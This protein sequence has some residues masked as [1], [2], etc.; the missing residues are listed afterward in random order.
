MHGDLITALSHFTSALKHHRTDP[1]ET[2]NSREKILEQSLVKQ[3]QIV[4]MLQKTVASLEE[5]N[6]SAREKVASLERRVHHLSLW[7]ARARLAEERLKEMADSAGVLGSSSAGFMSL[8][9]I[10]SFEKALAEKD[11][12][13]ASLQSKVEGK[14]GENVEMAGRDTSLTVSTQAKL[15]AEHVRVMELEEELLLSREDS[16]KARGELAECQSDMMRRESEIQYL[17]HEIEAVKQVSHHQQDV[18]MGLRA[19]LLD[20]DAQIT[21]LTRALERTAEERKRRSSITHSSSTGP[22]SHHSLFDLLLGRDVFNVELSRDVANGE[23]G[24]SVS[25]F[26][27]PISSRMSGLIVRAVREG[28]S[29][30]GLLVPGDEILEVNGLNCRNTS[31]KKAV[32]ILERGVGRIKVVAAREKGPSAEFVRMKISPIISDMSHSTSL[33]SA[34]DTSFTTTSPSRDP[35][36]PLSPLHHNHLSLP[37]SPGFTLGEIPPASHVR[38][39]PIGQVKVLEPAALDGPVTGSKDE[40]VSQDRKTVGE[41]ESK[42]EL[43]KLREEAGQWQMLQ[44]ELEGELDAT[45]SELEA[46][47]MEYQ[48]TTAEN[49]D[50]QQQVKESAT[51]LAHIQGQVEELQQLLEGVREKIVREEERTHALEQHNKDLHEAVAEANGGRDLEKQR[52][53]EVEGEMMQLKLDCEREKSDLSMKVASLQSHNQQLQADVSQRAEQLESAQSHARESE[54]KMESERTEWQLQIQ[55][56]KTDLQTVKEEAAKAASSSHIEAEKLQSQLT[57]VKSLLMSAEKKEA[58]MKIEIRHLS[59]A[60]DE[61]NKQLE[62]LHKN[63]RTLRAETSKFREQAEEKTVQCETLTLGLKRAECKLQANKEMSSRQ[64]NEIDKLR[65]SNKQLHVERVRADEVCSKA[66]LQ[67]RISQSEQAQVREKLQGQTGEKEELFSQL[68]T[69]ATENAVLQEQLDTAKEKLESANG[70]KQQLSHQLEQLQNELQETKESLQE[71]TGARKD[72]ESELL[73]EQSKAGKLKTTLAGVEA[74][75]EGIRAGRKT[76]DNLVASMSFVH[77]Q[78]QIRVKELEENLS[79]TQEELEWMRLEASSAQEEHSKEVQALSAECACLRE[80]VRGLSA[81]LHEEREAR[82]S[83]VEAVKEKL[84]SSDLSVKH[85]QTELEAQESV[86]SIN[87][88][89]ISQLQTAAEQAEEE[90]TLVQKNLQEALQRNHQLQLEVDQLQSHSRQLE[91]EIVKLGSEVGHLSDNCTDLKMSL[92][93]AQAQNDTLTAKL[94]A[95]EVNLATTQKRLDEATLQGRDMEHNTSELDEK[96]RE[97]ELNLEKTELREKEATLSL[98]AREEEI[99]QL[100]TQI[101]LSRSEHRELQSSFT[102]LQSAT[103]SQNKKIKTLETERANLRV[104]LEQLEAAQ[105]S[106]KRMVTSLEKE[107]V[108]L[109][110]QH[111]QEM[112]SLTQQLDEK[113]TTEKEHLVKI[114]RLERVHNEAQSTAEELL[115]AQDALKSS[116]TALGDEKE[117]E[118]VRLQE[119]MMTLQRSLVSS[120]Q[121]TSQARSRVEK[122]QT[123]LMEMSESERSA[124]TRLSELLDE[125]EQL[126]EKVESLKATETQLAEL[127][128]KLNT[129]ELSQKEKSDKMVA[130]QSQLEDTT[131]ELHSAQTENAALLE[132][133]GEVAAM[134]VA[135]AEKSAELERMK[136]DLVAE[137]KGRQELADEKEQLLGVLRKLEVEKHTTAVPVAPES[138]S[139]L[140]EADREVLLQ[141]T[142]EKEE[143][144]LRLREYVGKLL[145]AVVEKAPF[146]L[147]R[148]E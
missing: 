3:N 17:R 116:L 41:T 65:R 19:A 114:Q 33:K 101:E 81:Q 48:L 117:G 130:M 121:Q 105:H 80:R 120:Q 49:F 56:V 71:V 29:A 32:E 64:Q 96:F 133:V 73:I 61:S 16:G 7:K 13:I 89:T 83:E 127:L 30:Q 141:A 76:S 57:T 11:K 146:V 38:P 52:V 109:A 95:A 115:A 46:V 145:S 124:S 34:S 44:A 148:M 6:K 51:E 39:Q 75:V 35:P 4:E 93:Q 74:S 103:T 123:E 18:V 62:E 21:S 111:Q 129:L 8:T 9:A 47:K 131:K 88:A 137:V 23:L 108:H 118:V 126:R 78:D 97:S 26:E 67:L 45:H 77:E 70:E 72:L 42:E 60:A 110:E 94:Q 27:M 12:M 68:E 55:Q 37:S 102:L 100:K 79:R 1:V 82:G 144:A 128:C 135:L 5:E 10:S 125:N 69:L 36:S 136:G 87:K 147:E 119:Q 106:L 122:L 50:L 107:K 24:L 28:S 90:R 25:R 113:V 14:E 139:T 132:R 98:H 63:H 85:L 54:T 40:G 22:F 143:E 53:S 2:P 91:T 104:S 59:Q 43:L 140:Q 138:Q 92:K 20:R 15:V 86:S 66:E 99:S 134:T 58:E 31:Q 142:R 112:D 84:A